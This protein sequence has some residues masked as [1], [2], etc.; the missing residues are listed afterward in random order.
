MA[1]NV[2]RP[3]TMVDEEADLAF[4]KEKVEQEEKAVK[5]LAE[6]IDKVWITNQRDFK[7]IRAE[8][9]KTL[10]RVKGEYEPDKAAAIK[11]FKG[12]DIFVRSGEAKARSAESWIKDLYRAEAD[13]P[14]SIEPTSEPDL[15][16]ETQ[17]KI[18]NDTQQQ[19][20][21]FEQQMIA[22]G[23]E[24]DPVKVADLLQQYYEEQLEEERKNMNKRAKDRCA[25]A[26][27]VIKDQN[28]EGG[29]T[30]AFKNFLYSFVRVKFGV[31][32]GPILTKKKEQ[33][34]QMTEG[35]YDLVTSDTLANDVYAVS[36]FNIYPSE[37]ISSLEDGDLIEIH[38]LTR[39]SITDLLGVPG[40][41]DDEL[42]L[43]IDEI[44][45]GKI[46]KKWFTI[47][48][49]TQVRRAIKNKK[50]IT[51]SRPITVHATG[52][53]AETIRAQEFY[54]S[55]SGK[56]LIEWGLDA[57]LDS[58]SQYQVNCWKKSFSHYRIIYSGYNLWK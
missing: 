19:A 38:E 25:R 40:Y 6:H 4:I 22:S 20:L 42:R 56:L 32:K 43:V 13:M 31:I 46:K 8:M 36:P 10:R 15:P 21:A 44:D 27:S 35:G 37:G 49:E 18:K 3:N 16:K 24:I 29:W 34:W 53:G 58:H 51:D 26:S 48:D 7:P 39:Q 28:Q 30:N 55:V 1:L 23:L 54:G 2:N 45:S 17:E 12:S 5:K 57:T 14:W 52:D 50:E 33:R 41:S 9:V 11:A 47:E